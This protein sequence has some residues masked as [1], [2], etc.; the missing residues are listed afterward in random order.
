[1]LW[2]TIGM[3]FARR[4]RPKKPLFCTDEYCSFLVQE[5]SLI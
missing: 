3:W 5:E 1:M 4:D 2:K